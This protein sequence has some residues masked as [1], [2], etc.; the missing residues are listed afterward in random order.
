MYITFEGPIG[1]GKTTLA[2]LLGKH[3]GRDS[4]LVLEN[5]Q[6]NSFLADF[7]L[8]KE[9]WALP[10]QLDFLASRHEQL[11]GLSAPTGKVLIADHSLQKDRV[12]A[13]LLLKGREFELYKRLAKALQS[14]CAEPDLVVYLEASPEV[15]LE[16]IRARGRAYE[17]HIDA[18]YLESIDSAYGEY[19]DTLPA[20]K[21]LRVNTSEIDITS[22]DDLIRLWSS[23]FRAAKLCSEDQASMRTSA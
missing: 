17:S 13:K 14:E 10:M 23:I 18:Q 22:A 4:Q 15:L 21:L 2:R 16:R 5:F 6:D 1:A 19:L 20:S 9:R 12:F 7:Y 3:L 8:A 11:S